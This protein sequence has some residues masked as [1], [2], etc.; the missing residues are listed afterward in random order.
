MLKN[1]LVIFSKLE[2]KKYQIKNQS[3]NRFSKKKILGFVIYI[4]P[5]KKILKKAKFLY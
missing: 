1:I 5:T 2:N 4:N 3:K